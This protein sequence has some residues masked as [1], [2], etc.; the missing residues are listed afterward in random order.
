[1]RCLQD[2][3][4]LGM[5]PTFQIGGSLKTNLEKRLA[6]YFVFSKLL[7][8]LQAET[9]ERYHCPKCDTLCGP[10]IMKSVTNTHRLNPTE[11]DADAKPTQIGTE[12]FIKDVLPEKWRHWCNK[13]TNL[14][15]YFPNGLKF[16]SVSQYQPPS[17][18]KSSFGLGIEYPMDYSLEKIIKAIGEQE[19]VQVID[20]YMQTQISMKADQFKEKVLRGNDNRPLNCLSLEISKTDLGAE[21]HAPR[22]VSETGWIEAWCSKAYNPNVQ[23]YSIMSMA[24]SYTDFHID[25]G[26]SSVWYHVVKG[27]KRFF[28]IEPTSEN[29]SLFERWHTMHNHNE[30]FFGDLV[31]SVGCIEIEAGMSLVIPAGWIHAVYTP[32]YSLVLGGNFLT[33]E[34]AK[35]QLKIYEMEKRLKVAEKLRFPFFEEINIFMASKLVN[36]L[37]RSSKE[38]EKYA[39]QVATIR[40]IY[41]QLRRWQRDG[42]ASLSDPESHTLLKEVSKALKHAEKRAAM[43]G[44][45]KVV[46]KIR[47]SIGTS[48]STNKVNLTD[49]QDVRSLMISSA[50]APTLDSELSMAAMEFQDSEEPSRLVIASTK[51]KKRTP[52]PSRMQSTSSSSGIREVHQDSEFVYPSL[53][54]SD[55]EDIEAAAKIS[56]EDS[57]WRPKAKVRGNKSSSTESRPKRNSATKESVRKGLEDASRRAKRKREDSGKRHKIKKVELEGNVPILND[58]EP[59][60]KTCS[61]KSSKSNNVHNNKPNDLKRRKGMST[62]KQRL[63]RALGLKF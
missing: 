3:V 19:N 8:L 49:Q 32:E 6:F 16:E 40:V 26:G 15:Q 48:S 2:L 62:A 45:H 56:K 29:L 25:F 17:V 38:S 31:S 35:M 61:E 10:S 54:L 7:S 37:K 27:R 53:Q 46:P 12:T 39:K 21:I 33:S 14:V 58:K 44:G 22:F 1:M 51:P 4:P 9:L 13:S 34:M 5:C 60:S 23:K 41:D 42:A 57:T 18:F 36:G 30:K 28:V 20:C 47:F 43:H 59:T 52:A 55:D 50:P 24:G 11:T 63:G